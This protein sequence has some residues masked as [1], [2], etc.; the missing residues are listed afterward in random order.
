MQ[1]DCR[2]SDG[3]N[4]FKPVLRVDDVNIIKSQRFVKGQVNLFVA[5]AYR[6]MS[7][8]VQGEANEHRARCKE[9]KKW[10]QVQSP[11]LNV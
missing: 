2:A 5:T 4:D 9:I 6:G 8:D 10:F 7:I 1:H 3:M 11:K